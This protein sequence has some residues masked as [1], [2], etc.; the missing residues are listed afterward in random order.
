MSSIATTIHSYSSIPQA[1]HDM[2][3]M[4]ISSIAVYAS[5]CKYFI[6][7]APTVTLKNPL[8]GGPTVLD[9]ASY[10]ERGYAHP[11]SNSTRSVAGPLHRPL[12]PLVLLPL[13]LPPYLCSCGLVRNSRRAGGAASSSG[14]G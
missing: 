14:P 3:R 2:K 10:Q 13:V 5:V 12:L 1:N 4:S 6:S 7:L 9:M 11:L 8:P